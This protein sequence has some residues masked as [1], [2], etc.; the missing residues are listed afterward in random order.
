[1]YNM[2]TWCIVFLEIYK[3]TRTS[4]EN[5]FMKVKYHSETI[6]SKYLYK[7]SSHDKTYTAKM[8]KQLIM[9]LMHLENEVYIC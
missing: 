1:M 9:T 5:I 2:E 7:R 4:K 3:V 8:N 6:Q